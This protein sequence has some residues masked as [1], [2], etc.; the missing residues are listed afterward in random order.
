MPICHVDLSD[1]SSL[2]DIYAT[3]GS[4]ESL[5]KYRLPEKRTEPRAAYAFV[6]DELLLDG[7][8]RQNLATFARPGWRMRSSS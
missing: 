6:R 4:Q 8:A 3:K 5:P 7:N 1:H 2:L